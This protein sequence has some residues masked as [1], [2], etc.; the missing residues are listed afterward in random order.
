M[1]HV[2]ILSAALAALAAPAS[3]QGRKNVLE[4]LTAALAADQ[5]YDEAG[6][7]RLLS[8]VKSRFAD[9]GLQVVNES[10]KTAIPVVLHVITEGSFDEAPAERVAEV[11]FAAYQA[12][13]RGADPEVVEGIALY[14][15]RK[16]IPGDHLALWANGYRNLTENK[17]P[18]DVAADLVRVAMENG[19]PDSDFNILKWALVDAVKKGHDPKDYATYL[20]GHLSEG[21]TGPGRI[22]NDAALLFAK[23]RKERRR[24]SLPAYE[25]V[26]S[27]S[28]AAQAPSAPE[29][30]APSAPSET[31]IST[32]PAIEPPVAQT[33]APEAPAAEAPVVESRPSSQ[34]TQAP[35]PKEHEAIPPSRLL[36]EVWPGIETSARSYL[37]TPYVWGGT[38][39]KGIDCSAF[40]QNSYGENKV[41]IPR[42]SRDQWKA[43]DKVGGPALRDGDLLFFNTMGVGVSHVG[44]VVDAKTNK[45]MHAS[46]SKGVTYA[47]LD[48]NYYKQRYLGARR[49][50]P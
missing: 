13:S 29:P 49:V 18:S 15:Y 46:S 3:A 23:A 36:S 39:H 24:V 25:G 6:R 20:F 26:F 7:A 33:P 34:A 48:K 2:L 9:Y 50:V 44:M 38:T 37:G 31:P 14:G 47:D 11:A 10:R 21:K 43:G 40:T 42:V 35:A 45:F 8:A 22:A 30:S 1:I 5:G 4:T 17:I 27:K 41:R 28:V 19:L 16:K 12:M 32:V